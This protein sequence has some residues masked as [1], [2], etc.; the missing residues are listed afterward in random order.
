MQQLAGNDSTRRPEE[1]GGLPDTVRGPVF[2]KLNTFPLGLMHRKFASK[3]FFFKDVAVPGST[4][5]PALRK[6]QLPQVQTNGIIEPTQ[7]QAMNQ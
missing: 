6:E 4:Q 1:P 2:S 5:Y 7:Y 3:F